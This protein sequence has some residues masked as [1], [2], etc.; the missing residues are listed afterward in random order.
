MNE[1]ENKK[2]T[3]IGP[4]G[5]GGY[6][7]TLLAKTFPHVTLVARGERGKSIRANGITL[8]SDWSGNHTAYP[9]ATV[10]SALELPPQD[11]IFICVK[12]YSLESVCASLK[13]AVT[14]DTVIIPVMN[15]VDP[16]ERTRRYLQDGTVIDSLIY[17]VAF[18]NEDYSITQQGDGVRIYLGIE[19]ASPQEW[20]K[21]ESVCRMLSL[22][23]IP[24]RAAKDIQAE[25]WKKYILNC[26]YNV[27]TAYY[28][29][30]IGQLRDD[31]QKAA[32]YEALTNEAYQVAKKK[33]IQIT[34][35]EKEGMI[36]RFYHQMAYDAT[37]SL[38]RDILAQR[39]TE[40]E[41]F[42]GY[43]IKEAH[44]LGVPVP[45]SEMMYEGL[46]KMV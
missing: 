26:A 45:V 4:G 41:T 8:T 17:I 44:R 27:E 34:E 33:N 43:L 37:S 42:G 3:L 1:F 13:N 35:E 46:K 15:G 38:Q 32:Q 9:E 21:V 5:V 39:P 2:I 18:A 29:N 19:N 30:T 22:A 11:Y 28:N 31:P 24:C 23:K 40:L 20:E 14:R 7:G 16:G 10:E 25:I 36:E 12:Q 6:I